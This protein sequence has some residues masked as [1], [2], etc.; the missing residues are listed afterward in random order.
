MTLVAGGGL[1]KWFLCSL[2]SSIPTSKTD[3]IQSIH[4]QSTAD[5]IRVSQQPLNVYQGQLRPIKPIRHHNIGRHSDEGRALNEA[6]LKR[7]G[8]WS[9]DGHGVVSLSVL[10]S[11]TRK[12]SDLGFFHLIYLSA[13]HLPLHRIPPSLQAY[14]GYH[15]PCPS[16]LCS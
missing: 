1:D 14:I 15:A 6:S 13:S 2:Q 7:S 3:T 4:Y 9:C 11:T 12:L 5:G 8:K 10:Q 16:Q